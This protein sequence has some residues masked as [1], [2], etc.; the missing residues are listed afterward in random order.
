MNK[1]NKEVSIIFLN[2]IRESI[3]KDDM[4]MALYNTK[5]LQDLLLEESNDNR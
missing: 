4:R 5:C 1:T 2:M 3:E